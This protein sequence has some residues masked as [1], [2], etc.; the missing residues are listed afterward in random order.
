MAHALA[1]AFAPER[2]DDALAR[3]LQRVHV[4]GHGLEH[5]AAGLG[6]LGR[7]IVTLLGAGI[8][9]AAL[10]VRHRE[11]RQ[12]RERRG[13]QPL[14]PFGLGEIEP[15][16]RQRTIRRTAVVRGQRLHPGVVIVLDLL[17]P[18]AGGIFVQRFEH[19]RR[20]RHVVEDRFHAAVEQR[21]PMLH[22]GMAPAFAHRLVQQIIRRRRPERL[23][24]SPDG[25]AGSSRW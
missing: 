7:E 22:A 25:T 21:Q 14:A 16:R 1:G 12:T 15:I 23:P 9:D 5:V 17:E 3:R 4:L 24:R 18:L 20:P 10:P 2:D 11:R 19:D 13:V 8:D 6:A